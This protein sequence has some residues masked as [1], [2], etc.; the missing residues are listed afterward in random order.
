M[1][2]KQKHHTESSK[3]HNARREHDRKARAHNDNVY[4]SSGGVGGGRSKAVRWV[5]LGIAVVIVASLTLM[6]MAG[7]IEW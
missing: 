6:F 4:A 2:K 3:S 1:S 7:W 5:L